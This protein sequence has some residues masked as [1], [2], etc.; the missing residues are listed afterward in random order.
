MDLLEVE[1]KYYW[2][3]VACATTFI[4]NI[5]IQRIKYSVRINNTFIEES[6]L[7]RIQHMP[8]IN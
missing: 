3:S 8:S 2:E 5:I 1:E 6:V 4:M 7:N